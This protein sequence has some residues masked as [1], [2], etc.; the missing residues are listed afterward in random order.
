MHMRSSSLSS[1]F[2]IFSSAAVAE[3]DSR[4]CDSESSC[5]V[6]C[7]CSFSRVYILLSE[8]SCDLVQLLQVRVSRIRSV[9]KDDTL[10]TDWTIR[11]RCPVS[12][13]S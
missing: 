7:T 12:S 4:P 13:S 10:C 2:V 11:E 6:D 1:A 9:F 5:C 8:I 3:S